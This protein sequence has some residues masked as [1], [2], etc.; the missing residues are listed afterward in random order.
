MNMS[1]DKS[2]NV[3]NTDDILH[4]LEKNKNNDL[5]DDFVEIVHREGY[6]NNVHYDIQSW[7]EVKPLRVRFL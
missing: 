6:L 5:D 3:E 7:D 1:K 2:F 4:Y